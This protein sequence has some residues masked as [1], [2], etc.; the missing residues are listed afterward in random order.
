[1]RGL[2]KSLGAGK[3]SM[4]VYEE[5]HKRCDERSAVAFTLVVRFSR[6]RIWTPMHS[7][8]ITRK[9]NSYSREVAINADKQLTA[10]QQLGHTMPTHGIA[11][12]EQANRL[13]QSCI[14]FS[15][16]RKHNLKSGSHSVI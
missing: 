14:H 8:A 12:T 7:S 16:G 11:Q 5:H 2:I 13:S 6:V 4:V 10:S 15:R 1:M 3:E 9:S